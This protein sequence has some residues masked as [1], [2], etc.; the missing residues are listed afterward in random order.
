MGSIEKEWFGYKVHCVL[1]LAILIMSAPVSS[2]GN[3]SSK[4]NKTDV[5]HQINIPAMGAID[6]FN[7]LITQTETAF[8]FPYDLAE[9]STT[10]AVKGKY[11]VM[12]ALRL[13]LVDSGLSS[14]LSE[15]GAIRI[16][17]SDG[18]QNNNEEKTMKFQ[19]K[20]VAASMAVL[21]A[22]SINSNAIA[23]EDTD[24]SATQL[25]EVVV[26][27]SRRA[28]G[29]AADSIAPIDIISGADFTRN[30]SADPLD[31]LRTTV[32]A[33]NVARE[34]I[35]DAS[36]I[37]R[38][39]SLR[40]LSSDNTLVLVNG[41][42]RHRG[43]IISFVGRGVNDGAQ[44][45]DLAAI[46]SLALKQ[47]E[48]LR[49]GA[50]SQYGSDAIAGVINFS[51]KD[52]IEGGALQ[53]STGSTFEGDGDSTRIAGN[54][55]L[56]LGESGFIN[57]TAEYG[58]VDGTNRSQIRPD[59][60]A[61][62]AA[63]NTAAADNLTINRRFAD[64]AQYYGQPDI[65]DDLKTFFN[66]GFKLSD[67]TELYSFGSYAERRT[68]GG[69]FYRNPTNRGG[70]YS[71]DGGE[72]I[73]VGDLL[74]AQDGILD[75]S[76]GCPVVPVVNNRPE[77]GALAAL[78]ANPNCFSFV[79]TIPGGFNPRFGGE[80]EDTSFSVGVRGDL[81]NGLGYDVSATYGESLVT[82]FINNTLNP[83][84]GANSP[85]DFIAG[86]QEQ[87]EIT[88]N[89]D[90]TY[91]VEVGL[92]SDL[93]IGFGFEYRDETYSLIAGDPAATEIG[94]LVNQGFSSGTNGYGSFAANTSD[95]QD[96]TAAYIDL[97]ADVTAALTLQ[98][99]LR[100]EDYSTFGD[101]TNF[102]LGGLY[103]VNDNLRIRSTFS[104]GFHA[105][106]AGQATIT[107]IS[108]TIQNGVLVAD[109]T[110]AF[111]SAAGQL[112][113]DFIASQGNGRPTLGP[114]EAENFSLGLA[115][116][117]VGSSWTVDFYNIDLEDRV[118]V[119][120]SVNFLDALNFAG[121]GTNFTTVN[122]ALNGL[123]AAGVINQAEFG[124]LDD[125][126]G[127]RFFSNSFDTNTKGIDIVGRTSFDL[128]GGVSDLILSLNYN[129]T[130]VENVG[131]V[132]AIGQRRVDQIENTLPSVKGNLTW[133]HTQGPI[134]TLVRANYFGSW[135]D[136]AAGVL[137]N[138]SEVLVDIELAYAFE[139]GLEII[140]GANNVF[141]VY[142]PENPDGSGNIYLPD[143]PYGFNGGEYYLKARYEF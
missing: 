64:V 34:P 47:V 21:S 90:F 113:A 110:L 27:G 70:I 89:A 124:G 132:N 4:T 135:D 20:G 56:P 51:L 103:R 12:Q 94:A 73:L 61:L 143:G 19:K 100:Y 83:S 50:S 65:D 69:F 41:K 87:E 116:D 8:L 117:A 78:N 106:S 23:Q 24:T 108:T 45:V 9:K 77:P 125:L 93:N 39:A 62:I 92:A 101:T 71:V 43:A 26:I 67:N 86:G 137:N 81:D 42:R 138:P 104:T 48:V 11:T 38:P 91:G 1:L 2:A 95:S 72:T 111:D 99:A 5:L 133:S 60:A 35:T 46:P 129:K 30:A 32:P 139:N 107:N 63:G 84:L 17:M 119:G 130:K 80:V 55:G 134:R 131:T 136:P 22:M 118:S 85:R 142:P 15:K 14:G 10:L 82:V 122:A 53:V 40:G 126:Q 58:E 13:M 105:P 6:A 115:F 120:N 52:D 76:A 128:S 141:D 28:G 33:F 102:K 18:S 140:A 59:V 112:G 75:G 29:S 96:N 36:A 49:D 88:L 68:E 109:A 44:G 114:E 123:G 57:L 25:E 7:L 54:I 79:Q 98:A 37:S 16:F 97:E 66:A 3:R 121:G 127:F 74:D 31:L